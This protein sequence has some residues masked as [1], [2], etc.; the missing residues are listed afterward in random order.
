MS[1]GNQEQLQRYAR[2]TRITT[3][4]QDIDYPFSFRDWS[5]SY[6]GIIPGQEYTLYNQYL[7]DWYKAKATTTISKNLQIKLNYLNLLRQLQLFFKNEE[8]E[9]WYSQINLEND[10]ELLLAIPYFAKKLKDIA[11]YYLSLRDDVKKTKI[12]YNL[13][14]TDSGISLELQEFLL[15]NYTKKPNTYITIPASVW[16]S[17]PD[18][19]AVQDPINI[20]I[21]ELYDTFQYLDHSP[22]LPASA[23][24]DIN[25]SALE[26]YFNSLGL[27]LTSTEWV[28]KTG[29]FDVSG[30]Q[31][32]DTI[33]V[34]E[35]IANK[36][37]NNNKFTSLFYSA[38]TQSDNYNVTI[39]QGNN[40]FYWPYGPYKSNIAELPRYESIPL[41]AAGIETLATGGSS[42]ELADT[43]FIKTV[44]GTQGAWLRNILYDI[45]QPIMK[46]SLNAATTTRFRFPYPGFGLSAEDLEWTGYGFKTNPFFIYQPKS[47]KEGIENL[48]WSTNI[49]LTSHDTIRLNDTQLI[50]N[51]AYPSQQF[52]FADKIKIWPVPP[53]YTDSAYSGSV[54]E[55]WLYKMTQTDISVASGSDTTIVWPYGS[56]NP[57]ETYPV[58]PKA[59]DS[60]CLPIT[61]SSINF[62]YGIASNQLSSADMLLKI[63]N[64]QDTKEL[65]TEGVWLSGVTKYYPDTRITAV[66]QPGL[67]C[68]FKPGTFTQFIWQGED[69]ANSNTVFLSLKHQPDCRLVT[70]PNTT[71]KDHSLCTCRQVLFTPF[72]HPGLSFT[73]NASYSDYIIE[74]PF[75]YSLDFSN[76]IGSDGRLALDNRILTCCDSG[77]SGGNGFAWFKTE[78]KIG[79]GEGSWV[80]G[81]GESGLK[82]RTGR[83]YLYF[84]Q[85]LRDGDATNNPFPGYCV[86]YSYNNFNSENFKWIQATKDIDNKWVNANN[87]SLFKLYPG[88]NLLYS[89]TPETTFYVAKSALKTEIINENRGSLWSNYD[90]LTVPDGYTIPNTTSAPQQ[91]ILSYPSYFTVN[92]NLTSQQPLVNINNANFVSISS[93]EVTDPSNNTKKYYNTQTLTITPNLTGLYT[94]KVIAIS[95]TSIPPEVVVRN[96]G[97]FYYTNTGLYAFNAIPAVTAISGTTIVYP[98]SAITTPAPGFVLNTPLFGWDYNTSQYTTNTVFGDFGAKPFWAVTANIKNAYTGYKGIN[99]WG[100]YLRLLDG[101]NVVSQPEISDIEL[102]TGNYI[103]Y[104]RKGNTDIVWEEQ[105]TQ[106]VF[107]NRNVWSTLNFN[108]TSVTNLS[109]ASLNNNTI[110]LVV[111]SL[112]AATPLT[113]DS[114]IDNEPVEIYYNAINPFFWSITATPIITESV[115][116]LLSGQQITNVN[117]PWANFP[118]RYYPNAA[119]LPTIQNLSSVTDFGGFFV[120]QN[121]GATQYVDKDYTVL[122]N[123]SSQALTGIYESNKEFVGGRG[124]TKQD[125]LSPFE[126][127]LENN[128]WLKEPP[129]S[130]PIAGNIKKNIFKKYQKFIPYQTRY[131]SNPRYRF[132]I[133]TPSSRQTPWT[134]PTDSDWG[135]PQN[136]PVSYTGELNVDNW[137]N[138]Q[139]LKE[140]RLQLD[141]WVTDIFGNQYGLYKSLSGVAPENRK[142]ITGDVWVRKNSQR[143]YPAYQALSGVFDTYKNVAFYNELTG[144]GIKQID[145]F[146]DTLY[147]QTTGTIIFEKLVYEFDTDNLFS[148]ADDSRGISLAMPVTNNLTRE[149]TNTLSNE[150]VFANAGETW[151]F[152][153]SKN[154]IQSVCGLSGNLPIPE[155]YKYSINSLTLQKVFPIKQDDILTLNSLSSLN[156]QNV[157]PPLLTHNK[158]K[159]E[160]VLAFQGTNNNNRKYL[161]ELLINDYA[162]LDLKHI[163]V[164]SVRPFTDREQ[165]MP[166]TINQPLIVTQSHTTPFYVDLIAENR[167]VT[168][169]STSLPSWAV[170]TTTGFLSGI[171]PGP[172]VYTIPFVVN[173]TT[174]PT[175][176]TYTINAI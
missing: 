2:P 145:V 47:V 36:Y 170:L 172:G 148:I 24:Y 115:Y 137:A 21:E 7:V 173:N 38:S 64:Y 132:G 65:A 30:N 140:S 135:D 43:I 55:A 156:L 141:Q 62:S 15:T 97:T 82:L 19:S 77:L 157:T 80:T 42:L 26:T 39:L 144:T 155:L 79:F 107:T 149:V 117:R 18:L 104:E 112:T 128:T 98:A 44:R 89:R 125:Q 166:P 133:T 63:N 48:Y 35:E 130:G 143:T 152:P 14:G 83:S 45:T 53:Q 103:E 126:I 110:D 67:N 134:G 174:G 123:L 22:T 175:Y 113:L 116:S 99:S 139:I 81:S 96:N 153:E 17:V 23:Y 122:I 101:Y 69:Y 4:K 147:I 73:D 76:W 120:P 16:R 72:G 31:I 8:V 118:S 171:T 10:K 164:Y 86:R 41:S 163:T 162:T 105:I 74:N 54:S 119:V 106:N 160:Y 9:S 150:Q 40:F 154:V 100:N 165:G 59:L 50:E 167:P 91:F 20:Q 3:N 46:A 169:S 102:N 159:K 68:V 71:Y 111:T 108:T 27:A 136:Y 29:V 66:Q 138:S 129:I 127:T 78:N 146:F 124:L 28:Y 121:L 90:Y 34:S 33:K 92:E 57:S 61:L 168:F 176:Y 85:T 95:A 6:Q 5:E 161:I 11:L 88:E 114:I 142:N 37:L 93:W 49:T 12:K 60:T 25:F 56:I 75:S 51:K 58:L 94:F 13:V 109:T 131:E 32:V 87:V 151:F 52:N 1:I 70:T 84:R 158:I